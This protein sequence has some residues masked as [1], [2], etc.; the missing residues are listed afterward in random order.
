LE[1]FNLVGACG[2]RQ[3][4]P[5]QNEMDRGMKARVTPSTTAF[6]AIASATLGRKLPCDSMGTN[7]KNAVGMKEGATCITAN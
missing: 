3:Q 7:A 2:R 5:E 4:Q 1:E 6:G